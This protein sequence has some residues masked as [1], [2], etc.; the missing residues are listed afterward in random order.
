[1]AIVLTGFP[2][3]CSRS[4]SAL[5]FGSQDRQSKALP[6]DIPSTTGFPH[7]SHVLIG[8]SSPFYFYLPGLTAPGGPV[9]QDTFRSSFCRGT[10]SADHRDPRTPSGHLLQL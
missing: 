7:A 6:I 10:K 5:T 2:A 3:A 9:N 1:M 4:I 8:F